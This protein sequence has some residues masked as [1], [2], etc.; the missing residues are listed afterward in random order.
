MIGNFLEGYVMVRSEDSSKEK[1][2][3]LKDRTGLSKLS[4]R[5]QSGNSSKELLA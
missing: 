2:E 3:L 4:N 5:I 1:M